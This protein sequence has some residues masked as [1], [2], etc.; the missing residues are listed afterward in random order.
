MK[1]LSGIRKFYYI[2]VQD[3]SLVDPVKISNGSR[4]NNQV[5]AGYLNDQG[6]AFDEIKNDR[7]FVAFRIYQ[8]NL[9]IVN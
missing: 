4:K 8:F 5:I 2:F 7:G 6:V 3:S 1:I 9:K